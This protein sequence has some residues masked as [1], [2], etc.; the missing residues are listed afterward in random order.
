VSATRF[1]LLL[2][3]A[4]SGGCI[5][6]TARV[7]HA[8]TDRD[9]S[10][11]RDAIN[12]AVTPSFERNVRGE[13]WAP[14]KDSYGTRGG[15][16]SGSPSEDEWFVQFACQ[17]TGAP[18]SG[19]T[20]P[21][22]ASEYVRVLTPIQSDVLAAV[23]TAGVELTWTSAVELIDGPSPEAQF[24]ICYLRKDREI[25]GEVNGRLKSSAPGRDAVVRFSDIRIEL[26]EWYCK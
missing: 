11:V 10:A 16:A 9:R 25:A 6:G 20:W 14:R 15:F 12:G 22:P 18:Q 1:V 23:K 3:V 2:A 21:L 17:K 7:G 26:R 13:D 8:P 24:T 5:L 4:A 19:E